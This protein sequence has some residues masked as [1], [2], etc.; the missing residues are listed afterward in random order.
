TFPL[1]L[2]L[3]DWL[4]G[5]KMS[6]EGLR[7]AGA[8]LF[9]A[10]AAGLRAIAATAATPGSGAGFEAAISPLAYALVQG[11]VILLRYFPFL[12]V[13]YGFTVDPQIDRDPAPWLA[14]GCW[15]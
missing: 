4:R 1:F 2:L 13:P 8:M 6:A 9:L 7:P 14:V 10:L 11:P 3:V 5:R 15:T 12:V